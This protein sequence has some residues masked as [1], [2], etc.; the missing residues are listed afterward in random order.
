MLRDNGLP[1]L[2]RIELFRR[3]S[4]VD[5]GERSA[6]SVGALEPKGEFYT[7]SSGMFD[8]AQGKRGMWL[9]FGSDLGGVTVFRA[10][11]AFTGGP[12]EHEV[13]VLLSRD[14]LKNG[15]RV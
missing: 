13:A 12:R 11:P 2:E 10:S 8:T 14:R 9:A 15:E 7:W 1:S 4:Q 3:V 5:A 6:D